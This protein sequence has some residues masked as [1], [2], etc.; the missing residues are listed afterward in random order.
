MD[1]MNES[2]DPTQTL[3]EVFDASFYPEIGIPREGLEEVLDDFYDNVFPQLA[4]LTR[5]RADAAP[6]VEWALSQGFR[7]AIATDPLLP[8]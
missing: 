2:E 7:V 3:K 6:L 4:P 5:K 1:L 8:T